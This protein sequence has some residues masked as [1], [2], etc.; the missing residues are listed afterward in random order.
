MRPLA[1]GTFI[2]S[3]ALVCGCSN[4][5][6]G[7]GGGSGTGTATGTPSQDGQSGFE[8]GQT[9]DN[10]S[11]QTGPSELNPLFEPPASSDVT[12]SLTGLWAGTTY[13]I[14]YDVRLK[15]TGNSLV[16]A[17]RCRSEPAVGMTVTARVTS[18]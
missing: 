5:V 12:S 14:E 11:G 6:P 7:T 15:V 3:A 9:K 1:L 18:T 8:E 10:P 16:I 4:E 13:N 17:V 2:A